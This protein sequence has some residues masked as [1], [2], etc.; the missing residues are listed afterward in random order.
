[1]KDEGGNDILPEIGL[2]LSG[3]DLRKFF[4]ASH[5]AITNTNAQIR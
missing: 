3:K 2:F 5:V 1:M 4:K